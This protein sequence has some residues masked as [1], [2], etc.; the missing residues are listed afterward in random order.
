MKTLQGLGFNLG[1]DSQGREPQ[2]GIPSLERYVGRIADAFGSYLKENL[3]NLGT[4]MDKQRVLGI[5]EL[6]EEFIYEPEGPNMMG[7][8]GLA[9]ELDLTKDQADKIMGDIKNYMNGLMMEILTEIE[10]PNDQ[11][12]AAVRSLS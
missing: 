9:H 10:M 12:D 1:G 8:L 7:V 6:V 4:H 3:P 5:V 11:R 2:Q